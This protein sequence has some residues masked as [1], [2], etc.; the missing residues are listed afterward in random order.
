MEK[1]SCLTIGYSIIGK[2]EAWI[3]YLM[4]YVGEKNGLILGKDI[5][6]IG[7]ESIGEFE[8]YLSENRNKTLMGVV[9]CTSEWFE[10]EANLTAE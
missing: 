4:D 10:N 3:D 7:G 9:F 6:E 1:D 2:R 8:G 5:K